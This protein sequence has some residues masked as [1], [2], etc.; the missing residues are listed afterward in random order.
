MDIAAILADLRLERALI[1]QAIASLEQ[2]SAPRRRRGRPPKR[3]TDQT[4]ERQ[5]LQR[6][7]NVWQSMPD[8]QD[9]VPAPKVFR[10]GAAPPL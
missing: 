6:H 4:V 2:I 9:P 10:A 7:V 5:N 3:L 1:E 8:V